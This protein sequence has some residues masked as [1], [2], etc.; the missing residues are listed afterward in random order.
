MFLLIYIPQSYT[1]QIISTL[2]IVPIPLYISHHLQILQSLMFLNAPI[3]IAAFFILVWYAPKCYFSYLQTDL[4]CFLGSSLQ[5]IPDLNGQYTEQESLAPLSPFD[6]STSSNT[7]NNNFVYHSPIFSLSD[8][9]SHPVFSLTP[10][11]PYSSP[12]A[13]SSTTKCSKD[14]NAARCSDSIEQSTPTVS[15]SCSLYS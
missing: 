2:F 9:V 4:Q 7:D 6:L 3:L 5:G 1:A 14:L 11:S 8:S 13:P 12:C 10:Y 15:P